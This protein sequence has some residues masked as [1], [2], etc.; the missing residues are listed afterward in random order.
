MNSW[1]TRD[2]F[3]TIGCIIIISLMKCVQWNHQDKCTPDLKNS[4]KVLKM[5]ID[6]VHDT[7]VA[8]LYNIKIITKISFILIFFL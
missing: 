1:K 6:Y 8:T 5:V 7:T 2:N 3:I 4:Y